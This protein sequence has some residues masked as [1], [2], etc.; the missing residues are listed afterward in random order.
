MNRDFGIEYKDYVDQNLP[1]LWSRIEPNLLERDAITEDMARLDV[2][3]SDMAVTIDETK[4]EDKS[5]VVISMS[6][7]AKRAIPFAAAAVV[8]I[9]SAKMI[10]SGL[11]DRGAASSAP[12]ADEAVMESATADEMV[13]DTADAAVEMSDA[14]AA[15]TAS[16]EA[17]TNETIAE[18]FA[19]GAPAMTDAIAD[20]AEAA[21]C[22]EETSDLA[23]TKNPSKEMIQNNEREV[24]KGV[25][26]KDVPADLGPAVT[27]D[28]AHFLGAMEPEPEDEIAAAN[29][30]PLI[31]LFEVQQDGQSVLIR[32]YATMDMIER[33]DARYELVED[34]GY[35]ISVV[36]LEDMKELRETRNALLVSLAPTE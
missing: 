6:R 15:E 17:V 5:K 4:Q 2:S 11:F 35:L 28:S 24:A 30:Y 33:L 8:L 7:F 13:M 31:M 27:Y 20:V 34:A 26:E 32:A 9:F 1:D 21:D 16:D 36:M 25:Y 23:G 29:G 19:D 18:S 22:E 3:T 10:Q 12:R 14:P